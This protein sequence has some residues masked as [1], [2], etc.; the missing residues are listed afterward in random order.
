MMLE[1]I[2]EISR[3]L[4]NEFVRE[5]KSK[6]RFVVGHACIALPREVLEA[7][8]I[9][10]FRLRG[11]SNP[12]TSTADSYL[13]RYNCSFCRSCLELVLNG[14]YDFLDGFIRVRGCDHWMGT[15]DQIL[16]TK[17]P[18]FMHYLKVP[19]LVNEDTLKFFTEEIKNL[20][21]F[22]EKKFSKEITEDEIVNQI[23]LQDRITEKLKDFSRKRFKTPYFYGSDAIAVAIAR[24]SL[25]SEIFEPL[26][27][28]ALE[29]G[30]KIDFRAK[31]VLSGSPLDE[32]ELLKKLEEMGAVI[33]AETTCFGCGA[34]WNL[35]QYEGGDI[36]EFLSEK[37]LRNLRIC[38]RMFGEYG[39]RKNF[40]KK[41]FE[42]SEADGVILTHNKFCDL[43]GIENAKLRLDLEKEG[44]PVLLLEKEYASSADIGRIKTRVQAFM[45]RLGR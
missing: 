21:T 22:F 18:N 44:I 34:F 37:Y 20:K 2:Y 11:N 3:N 39:F 43:F 26:L 38:A 25:P 9:M 10:P 7:G 42:I 40:L 33:V 31:F 23:K 5:W 27:N 41:M 17:K 24:E 28:K 29:E 32:I 19:H 35:K 14:S 36:Y 6:G 12:D 45:E 30:K 13:S 8:K 4:E 16:Y 15:F 1:K